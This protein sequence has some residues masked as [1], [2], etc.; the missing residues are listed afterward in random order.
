MRRGTAL[1]SWPRCF[2]YKALCRAHG[3]F[4]PCQKPGASGWEV[5]H[6]ADIKLVV[7][8]V[9]KSF[10][11]VEGGALFLPAVDCLARNAEH[12]SQS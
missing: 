3:S 8:P 5:I 2:W 7:E 6:A 4:N 11:G 1:R 10:R 12:F 9:E